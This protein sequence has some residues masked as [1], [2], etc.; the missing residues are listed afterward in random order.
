MAVRSSHCIEISQNNSCA[1]CGGLPRNT[2]SLWGETHAQYRNSLQFS[3]L[4]DSDQHHKNFAMI[5]L[6]IYNVCCSCS[7]HIHGPRI[8]SFGE[9]DSQNLEGGGIVHTPSG[10]SCIHGITRFEPRLWSCS[11][12]IIGRSI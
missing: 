8:V 12:I 6:V 2:R 1:R 3:K 7:S 5:G 11:Q 9:L 4:V 10:T